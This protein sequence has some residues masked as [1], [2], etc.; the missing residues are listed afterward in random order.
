[1]LWGLFPLYFWLLRSSGPIEILSHRVI[2]SAL[3]MMLILV[4]LRPKQGIR[5][6]LADR[7]TR[8]YLLLAALV[9]NINWGTYIYGVTT[10]RVVETSLGYFINPLVTVLMGVFLLGEHL[11]RAQW[12]ALGIAALAIIGLTIDYGHPPW[13]ALTLALSFAIYGL[14]KKKANTGAISS[15]TFETL[16][17]SPVAAA[18]QLWLYR[19]TGANLL[20]QGWHHAM[21]LALSGL[22]TV[23]PLMLFGAAAI[24]LS[25]TTLGILQ[26]LGPVIQFIIGVWIFQEHMSGMR[27][28]GF[29]LVWSALVIFT[30]EAIHHLRKQQQLPADTDEKN[31]EEATGPTP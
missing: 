22:V 15:L 11:R 20:D 30:V 31:A 7:S 6:I 8:N 21:L 19:S 12:L 2:W 23:I 28:A 1:M 14:A 10:D 17:M 27:W 24:R 4:I 3:T 29:V 16:A 13:I 25:L 18:Y 5:S 26:Y 9:V